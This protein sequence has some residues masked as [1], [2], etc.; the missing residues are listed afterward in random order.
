MK[1]IKVLLSL[2]VSIIAIA[3]FATLLL[4]AVSATRGK[5]GTSVGDEA[6]TIAGKGSSGQSLSSEDFSGKILVVDFW[7]SWCPPCREKI[8]DL[9][10]IQET[11][12]ENVQ[13]LGVN[14]DT[15][16]DLL[17]EY[18]RVNSLNFP[19]IH[20]GATSIAEDF[21]VNAIPLLLVIDQEGIIRARGHHLNLR[22]EIDTLLA[23]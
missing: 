19:S 9:V 23:E 15:K 7:A 8:P 3:A 6:L 20:E 10:S 21:G 2:G 18:E 5:E 4:A 1:G 13:V 16:A 14:L 17:S 12:Q 11:Y 22:Q